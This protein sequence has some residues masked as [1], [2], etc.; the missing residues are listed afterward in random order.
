MERKNIVIVSGGFAF[1]TLRSAITY[2]LHAENRA[3]FGTITTIY[4]APANQENCCIKICW[5]SGAHMLR[6]SC[7]NP[8][9]SGRRT[10]GRGG[11]ARLVSNILK[12]VSPA[13]QNAL[14][15]VCGPPAMIRFTISGAAG[16][17]VPK[18]TIFFLWK[19]DE[20]RIGNRPLQYRFKKYDMRGWPGLYVRN[21]N[22]FRQNINDSSLNNY[23]LT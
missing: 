1:T 21:S 7:V 17:R 22:T 19:M 20:M 5:H 2:M 6:C 11:L 10:T 4:G 23:V 13:A 16:T 9:I 18:K 14:A 3:C 15:L 8:L 12:E